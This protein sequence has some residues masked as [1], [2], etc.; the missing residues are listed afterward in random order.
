M[1]TRAFSTGVAPRAIHGLSG[2]VYSL[3]ETVAPGGSVLTSIFSE[4]WSESSA[5]LAF[6]GMIFSACSA[7]R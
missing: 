7:S 1:G 2:A 5:S 3:Y 4:H 6:P